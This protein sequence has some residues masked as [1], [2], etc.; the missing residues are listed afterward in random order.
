MKHRKIISLPNPLL[1]Q[2]SEKVHVITPEILQIIDNMTVVALEW[3][4]S[5]PHEISAAIAAP[6][7]G[8]LNK[9]IMVRS[10]LEDKNI[11][12]FTT[13][14]NPEI[15]K[16]E[17]K[18]TKDYEGCLSVPNVYGKVP[19]HDKARIKAMDIN[20]N[21]IRLKAEGFL[22]RVLQ[23]EIDHINGIVFIDHI[24]NKEDAFYELDK[25]GELQPLDYERYVKNNSIL[26]D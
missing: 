23:H 17:G 3:E 4:N 8:Y 10:D 14:I 13:L 16:L 1:R 9:I 2:K 22:A 5:R 25:E 15:I 21:E 26:W 20:G 19:R 11:Q 18:V 24:R 12:D 6:Q 7:I